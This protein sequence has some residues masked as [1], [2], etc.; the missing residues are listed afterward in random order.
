MGD[1]NAQFVAFRS[2]DADYTRGGV[3]E[4][5]SR[6]VRHHAVGSSLARAYALYCDRSLVHLSLLCVTL[7]A[8]LHVQ[9]HYCSCT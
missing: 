6:V 7:Q 5:V 4:V 9:C 3:S 1:E 8:Y 2:H